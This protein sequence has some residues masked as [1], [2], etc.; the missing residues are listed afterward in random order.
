[1]TEREGFMYNKSLPEVSDLIW[2]SKVLQTYPVTRGEVVRI[3]RR[4]NVSEDIISLL[5]QF[6][7]DET[8]QSRLELVE[9]CEELMNKIRESW[10]MPAVGHQIQLL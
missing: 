8:F 10:E 2:L 1:M 7:I 5:R 9:R 6:P 4:W 3:A